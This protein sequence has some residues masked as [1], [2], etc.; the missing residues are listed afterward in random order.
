M[1]V[2]VGGF[3]TRGDV[4][5]MVALA[6]SL[7]SRGHAVR[8]AVSPSSLGL[9]RGY[10]FTSIGVGL[11]YEE[12]SRRSP[13]GSF[14]EVMDVLPLL[15][16]EIEAQ[17]QA[18]EAAASWSDL[19]I[20]SSVFT[21]GTILAERYAK[22]F[23]FFAFCPQLFPS[24]NHPTPS[25]PFHGLPRW[26]NRLSWA[27]NDVLWNLLFLPELKKARAA[28]QLRTVTSVWSEMV[29]K[30][31]VVACDSAL[32]TAP[33]DSGV[34]LHQPGAL[35]LREQGGLSPRL[36]RF[37][38]AGPPPVYLGFGSM[39]DAAPS[40]TAT[41]LV[42]SARD[43]G[44]RAVLSRGWAG[45]DVEEGDDVLVVGPEPHAQLFPRCAV[46]VHHGGAGT[47]HAA[48]RAGVPQVLM[49]Q[50]LDQHYWAHR[51]Q[52]LQIG[53]K[54]DRHSQDPSPLTAALRESIGLKANAVELA[55]RMRL[56]GTEQTVALLEKL[57]SN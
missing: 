20:G 49:P 14:T 37:L 41:R 31:P 24:S 36:E 33:E 15:R 44:M 4:Q 19:I 45:L 8:L 50:L 21:S 57:A 53:R 9:A 48:A 26:M 13:T 29:G 22:P 12:V 34:R 10:G 52:Q 5:P 54:V 18:M 7:E 40:R 17:L 11:D 55:K 51:V 3:G 6:Q 30:D 32:A 28:R 39:G 16:G 25:V 2:L 46:V 35:F 1:K 27:A 23:A 38:E 47:T 43:A 56:D 42:Q